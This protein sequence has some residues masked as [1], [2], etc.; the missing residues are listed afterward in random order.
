VD[1][2]KD[3]NKEKKVSVICFHKAIN[4]TEAGKYEV[5]LSLSQKPSTT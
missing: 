2:T 4:A 1:L 5:R 3:T